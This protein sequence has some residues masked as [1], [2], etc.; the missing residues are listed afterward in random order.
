MRDGDGLKFAVVGSA[1]GRCVPRDELRVS[2]HA[3]HIAGYSKGMCR[4]Y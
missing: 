4:G 3:V 1:R 2:R